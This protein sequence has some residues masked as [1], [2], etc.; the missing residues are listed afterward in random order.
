MHEL[1]LA[2]QSPR[3]K[4]ILEDRGYEFDI[5]PIEVS[6]ILDKNLNFLDRISD[7][8]R[9]KAEAAIA[10]IK[11]LKSHDVLV[12]SADTMVVFNNDFLGK[13]KN[14][15]AALD[16]LR[17]LS[18]QVHQV[19]TGFCLWDLKPNRFIL[20]QEISEV[21]FRQLTNEE[22]E[23][24]VNSGDPMDKAGSY[25]IQGEAGKFVESI[26][27]SFNNIVGLPIE[28]IEEKLKSNGW[29]IKK[30]S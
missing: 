29:I 25:G 26:Q 16:T 15:L 9:Q 18:G 3:R 22:I 28:N 5:F 12:L 14:K 6:E 4:Q 13:P 10:K 17:Q 8:A 19:I 1:I 7:C 21:R 2:S 27:G 20:G 11:P 30:Q 24:Y 23:T